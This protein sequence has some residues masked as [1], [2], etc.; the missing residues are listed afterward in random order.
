MKESLN[1]DAKF[2]DV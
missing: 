1:A 2:V